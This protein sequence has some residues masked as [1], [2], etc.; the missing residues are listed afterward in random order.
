[1]FEQV[2]REKIRNSGSAQP[3]GKR[4]VS[5]NVKPHFSYPN[6]CLEAAR[7]LLFSSQMHYVVKREGIV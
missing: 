2:R 6:A 5:S 1:M 7:Y 4:M 3:P